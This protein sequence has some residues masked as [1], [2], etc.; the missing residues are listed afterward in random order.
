MGAQASSTLSLGQI[1]SNMSFLCFY[2]LH[3]LKGIG[4][5]ELLRR[6]MVLTS[7]AKLVNYREDAHTTS[8]ANEV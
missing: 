8:A 1:F 3:V 2:L 5:L 4:I 7:W 6:M